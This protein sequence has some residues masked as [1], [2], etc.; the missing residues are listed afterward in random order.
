MAAYT[1]T[2]AATSAVTTDPSDD[3]NIPSVSAILL[4][5]SEPSNSLVDAQVSSNPYTTSTEVVAE[6]VPL[7]PWT[8]TPTTSTTL[9][10]S[11]TSHTASSS[12]TAS[13]ALVL[14]VSEEP[15][16]VTPVYSSRQDIR[17][18]K[19]A[20]AMLEDPFHKKNRRRKRRRAR[21]VLG[22]ATGI[23]VGTMFFGPI[24]GIA[25]LATAVAV[26]RT[27]SKLGEKLKDRRVERER[28]RLAEERNNTSNTASTETPIILEAYG[29][30]DPSER[31]SRGR[32][33]VHPRSTR[34][35]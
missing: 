12:S 20:R 15:H 4:P 23:V 18:S 11:N 30:A 8:K 19:L 2:F 5:P 22:G 16:T 31:P 25:G 26:T 1:S 21:M 29:Y 3:D 14:A 34:T 35:R 7:D 33:H 24:G 6:A 10:T 17:R 28:E 13:D 32:R 27:A 9:T